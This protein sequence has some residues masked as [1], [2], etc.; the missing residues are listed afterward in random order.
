MK[1]LVLGNQ[2]PGPANTS[3]GAQGPSVGIIRE[4]KGARAVE[5]CAAN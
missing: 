4:A 1:V 5:E 2:R 3:G